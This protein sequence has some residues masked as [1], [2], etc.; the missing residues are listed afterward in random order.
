MLILTFFGAPSFFRQQKDSWRWSIY[1]IEDL[2]GVICI[3][4]ALLP[5]QQSTWHL[6]TYFNKKVVNYKPN[7]A[8]VDE[9][10]EILVEAVFPMYEAPGLKKTGVPPLPGDDEFV[11]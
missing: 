5:Y 3:L 7:T 11:L 8:T 2:F 6:N 1:Y 4:V 10:V 9:T